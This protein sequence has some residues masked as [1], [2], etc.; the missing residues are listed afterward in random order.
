[1][2][3]M[4]VMKRVG[5]ALLLCDGIFAALHQHVPRDDSARASLG[6]SLLAL[7]AASLLMVDEVALCWTSNRA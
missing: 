4:H 2:K 5:W 7:G 3:H 1:M 6:I